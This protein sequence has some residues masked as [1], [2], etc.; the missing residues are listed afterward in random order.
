M[1]QLVL[2][3]ARSLH[4]LRGGCTDVASPEK[5]FER[6]ARQNIFWYHAA[7]RSWLRASSTGEWRGWSLDGV[8]QVRDS[9]SWTPWERTLDESDAPF[10]RWFAHGLTNAAF[11]EI[12]A[13]VLDGRGRD[14]AYVEEP[15]P[16]QESDACAEIT[17]GGLLARSASA[18]RYLSKE[19][20]LR[21][22]DRVVLHLP[23]CI[24]QVVWVEACKRLGVVYCCCNPGL[25]PEQIA[26]RV[27][28]LKAALVI[29]VEHPDWSG[30]VHQALN[31]HMPIDNARNMFANELGLSPECVEEHCSSRMTVLVRAFSLFG[32]AKDFTPSEVLASTTKLLLLGYMQ[33]PMSIVH[34]RMPKPRIVV[35]TYVLA[36]LDVQKSDPD[37]PADVAAIWSEYGPP[38]PVEANFPLFVIFTS[39]T[40]GKPKGICHAHAYVA[41]IV[42]TM[43][44][45]FGAE[46]G[47]DRMLT[48]GTLGWITGQSY[49]V[50][51]SLACGVMSVLM[52]GS[53]TRP[54][55]ARFLEVINR[56][57]VTI[58]KAGSAFLRD[59]MASPDGVRQVR[60]GAAKS[61]RVATFCAEVVSP[62]VHE[63]AQSAICRRYVN[64]YWATE[65]GGIAWSV[66][67][68]QASKADAHTWPLP[69][70]CAD[71]YVLAGLDRDGKVRAAGSGEAGDVVC[72]RPFP[73]MFRCIWGDV[74]NFGNAGWTGDRA[75]MLRK[76]WRRLSLLGKEPQWAYIQGD[77]AMKHADGSYTFHGRSD[78][79]L[80]VNGVL[81][82]SG[83]I[84]SAIL[85]DRQSHRVSC[86]GQCVV[87]GYPD[88]VAGEV[89]LAWISPADS[90]EPPDRRDI[91]RLFRLVQDV[92]GVVPVKFIFVPSLPQT[93]SG[94]FLRRLLADISK[95]RPSGDSSGLV[96]PDCVP[97]LIDAFAEWKAQDTCGAS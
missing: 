57:R 3:V 49:M 93:F 72:T 30:M 97:G 42:E 75:A 7:S 62:A 43:S 95:D 14:V 77:F 88:D 11:T 9:S 31:E 34:A 71:V 96:N 6:A 53:P 45:C 63:F 25:P 32:F 90:S 85:R 2:S 17:R 61:L 56:H 5:Y 91:L 50:S 74:E 16:L 84:E 92:V 65:H 29:S 79:V 35:E 38:V 82:G 59:V 27:A 58:F 8:S 28:E 80:N 73:H 55:K 70:V 76:S 48:I 24:E 23:T 87:V 13:H 4:M 46:L 22:G 15:D 86:V 10:Y 39:G 81:F 60:E 64:S 26:D 67:A 18:A 68:S 54:S 83:H 51:A 89:P 41:G 69:W 66:G 47:V 12:D 1:D 78:E 21:F 33:V 44:V 19:I 94:K 36:E 40:L 20:G 37:G 52:R